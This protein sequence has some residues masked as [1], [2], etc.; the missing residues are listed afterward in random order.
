MKI[1]SSALSVTIEIIYGSS[2]FGLSFQK[3]ELILALL[4]RCFRKMA[5]DRNSLD[6]LSIEMISLIVNDIQFIRK[7]IV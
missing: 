1:C 3:L 6:S 7:F 5:I 2:R 4:M